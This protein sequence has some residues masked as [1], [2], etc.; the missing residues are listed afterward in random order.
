MLKYNLEKYMNIYKN[1]K[2]KKQAQG[3]VNTVV[4]QCLKNDYNDAG[5]KGY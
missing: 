4:S 2:Q 5:R 1:N 3:I